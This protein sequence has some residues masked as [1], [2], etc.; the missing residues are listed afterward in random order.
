MW[1]T[2]TSTQS[3]DEFWEGELERL[4]TNPPSRDSIEETVRYLDS[5]RRQWLAGALRYLPQGH[6]FNTK[7]HLICGYDSVVC[8]G[9]VALNLAF[10]QYR[11]DRREAVY[12]LIHELSHA[13]YFR[14]HRMPNLS[15]VKT[16]RQLVETVKLLTHLEGMGVIG[17]LALRRRERGFL[18]RDYQ[19]LS[20]MDETKRRVGAY[21]AK[22]AELENEPHRKVNSR[23][24]DYFSARPQRLWYITGAH[25]AMKIEERYGRNLLRELVREGHRAFFKVYEGLEDSPPC[26]ESG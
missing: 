12:Y 17:P 7:V 4:R 22:L 2:P 21:F 15:G 24:L 5:H 3:I 23:T 10:R 16:G 14:Y 11:D 19:V 1:S 6:T 20:D 8:G 25:M 26:S 13:G 18:D 9:D